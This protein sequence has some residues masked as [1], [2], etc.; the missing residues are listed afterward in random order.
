[1]HDQD[2]SVAYS[3]VMPVARAAAAAVEVSPNPLR[4]ER[5]QV[6]LPPAEGAATLEL[7]T[8]QGRLLRRL[9]APAGTRQLELP[10]AGL[11]GGVYLLRV[12]QGSTTTTTRLVVLAP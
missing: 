7:L 12:R 5:A 6:L 2:G 8:A 11:A 4:G 9:T 3:S 1:M 10:T